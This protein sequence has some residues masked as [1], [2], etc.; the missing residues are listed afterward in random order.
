MQIMSS[1]ILHFHAT[2]IKMQLI[3]Y[4]HP[5]SS[6]GQELPEPSLSSLPKAYEIINHHCAL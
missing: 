1:W 5:P 4:P 6:G 3:K 2:I